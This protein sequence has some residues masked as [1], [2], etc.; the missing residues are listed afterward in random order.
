MSLLSQDPVRRRLRRALSIS[1]AGLVTV[2]VPLIVAAGENSSSAFTSTV[3][4][5]DV[6]S[7]A[8]SLTNARPEDSDTT[9][10][11]PSS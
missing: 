4:A 10:W 8:L 9:V 5:V 1:V 2:T 3:A 6:T 11:S 7:V